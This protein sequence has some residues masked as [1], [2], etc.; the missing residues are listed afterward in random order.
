MSN[1]TLFEISADMQALDEL[2]AD[3]DGN[4]NDPQI[5]AVLCKWAEEVVA[6]LEDKVDNYAA[7]IKTMQARSQ[8]R[9]EEAQRLRERARVDENAMAGLKSRLQMVFEYRNIKKLETP[10]FQIG[11]AKNGGL[12]PLE[13]DETQLGALP[14]HCKKIIVEP[15]NSAIRKELESGNTLPG[16]RLLERGVS[17]RIR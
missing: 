3:V 4:I 7:L 13:V 8:A 1:Q 10:R 5:D 11:L 17:L 14:E 15:N 16:C 12:Q 2:L 9:K 6:N